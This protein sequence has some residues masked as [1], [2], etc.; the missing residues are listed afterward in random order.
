MKNFIN[1]NVSDWAGVLINALFVQLM[2][3]FNH[4][5]K[6]HTFFFYAYYGFIFYVCFNF[7]WEGIKEPIQREGMTQNDPRLLPV[8]AA[9]FIRLTVAIGFF[10]GGIAIMANETS[11]PTQV[12]YSP[13]IFTMPNFH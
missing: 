7:F 3:F 9:Q 13:M 5:Y 8:Q 6:E 10:T 2:I 11:I 1:S 12:T 4:N